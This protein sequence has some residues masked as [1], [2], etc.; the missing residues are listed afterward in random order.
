MVWEA[1]DLAENR[2][3]EQGPCCRLEALARTASSQSELP[4][5]DFPLGV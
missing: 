2:A 5:E 1:A 4:S 3:G